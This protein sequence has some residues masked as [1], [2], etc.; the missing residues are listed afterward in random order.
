MKS[1]RRLVTHEE[2]RSRPMLKHF[3]RGC[4]GIS[5]VCDRAGWTRRLDSELSSRSY[6]QSG[7]LGHG[8]VRN[9]TLCLSVTAT[10]FPCE[11]EQSAV[12]L[13]GH[14]SRDSSSFQVQSRQLCD[15]LATPP[16]HGCQDCRRGVIWEESRRRSVIRQATF[17]VST[18]SHKHLRMPFFL[19]RARAFT[20]HTGRNSLAQP[21]R[22]KS[23]D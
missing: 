5:V 3:G 18:V 19:C 1:Q 16:K 17:N 12:R 14:P 20:S 6:I 10:P 11:D 22:E 23:H 21:R 2:G 15:L 9:A 8:R 4:K 7:W 13:I